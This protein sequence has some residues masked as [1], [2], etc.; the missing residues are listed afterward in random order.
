MID[1]QA[2]RP[3]RRGPAAG[4]QLIGVGRASAGNL[5]GQVEV[6]VA[7][8]PGASR[9]QP[10][11]AAL[12]ACAEPPGAHEQ[13]RREPPRLEP[14]LRIGGRAEVGEQRDGGVGV[15]AQE[16]LE[17]VLVELSDRRRDL[18][19]LLVALGE[20]VARQRAAAALADDVARR[21]AA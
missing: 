17:G 6:E 4:D 1:E 7:L 9:A 8:S 12:V 2:E 5:K 11:V 18:L 10:P 3:A 16:V 19:E 13:P 21:G 20:L 14:Q 15:R